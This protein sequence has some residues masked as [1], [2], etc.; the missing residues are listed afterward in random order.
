MTVFKDRMDYIRRLF[1][2]ETKALENARAAMA[3]ENDR[4]SIYP[5][6][7]KLLQVL[8]GLAGI[9][10]IVEVGTLGGYSALWMA[11]ALPSDGHLYTLEKD[12]ARAALARKNLQDVPNVTLVEGDALRTL[13]DLAA[14]GPFDMI[15]IDA[16]KLHYASYLDW[17]EKNI[18][19]GGLV[20]GDNTFLFDAVWQA[21]MP[22]RVRETA[23]AAMRDFNAR[24]A[25][26]ARYR[27]I[28]LPTAEGMTIAQKLFQ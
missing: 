20:V 23:R 6:E 1:A 3:A 5:E 14:K 18:R 16:D 19:K 26:P 9:R 13:G 25:D 21:E 28:V 15:F 4:I 27:A 7:G 11:G 12:P 2:P 17:A 22:P 24:L 8:I 10:T